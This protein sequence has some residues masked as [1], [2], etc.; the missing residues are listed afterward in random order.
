VFAAAFRGETPDVSPALA[1]K[2]VARNPYLPIRA[3]EI[4]RTEAMEPLKN[5]GFDLN[6]MGMSGPIHQAAINGHLDTVKKLV[7]LG[8]D[9]EL[10]DPSYHGNA[11]GWAEHNHQQAVIDYLKGLSQGTGTH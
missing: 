3:G 1:A 11:L 7:E 2:A 8:A 5:L 4:G 9:P 6:A 10:R